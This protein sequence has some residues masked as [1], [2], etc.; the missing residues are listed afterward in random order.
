MVAKSVE[1]ILAENRED[2]K[3]SDAVTFDTP[4]DEEWFFMKVKKPTHKSLSIFHF[5]MIF[6]STGH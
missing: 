6:P 1:N 2:V 4:I 3:T 5:K